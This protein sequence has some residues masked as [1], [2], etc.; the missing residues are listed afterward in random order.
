MAYN[1]KKRNYQNETFMKKL[2]TIHVLCHW[3][4]DNISPKRQWALQ[5]NISQI[6][7]WDKDFTSLF[8]SLWK[9]AKI[10]P[11]GIPLFFFQKYKL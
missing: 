5:R 3:V 6:L 11:K 4:H 10:T 7:I 9:G 2:H 8:Y 1:F